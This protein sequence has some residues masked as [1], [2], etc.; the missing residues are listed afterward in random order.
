VAYI[1]FGCRSSS[2]SC[3]FLDSNCSKSHSGKNQP[4]VRLR[5]FWRQ[6]GPSP[7]RAKRGSCGPRAFITWAKVRHFG[8]NQTWRCCPGSDTCCRRGHVQCKSAVVPATSINSIGACCVCSATTQDSASEA[9]ERNSDV[10]M[11]KIS[12]AVGRLVPFANGLTR[13]DHRSSWHGGGAL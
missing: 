11:A 9:A 7:N 10:G 12:S 5:S 13:S 2:A 8:R 4:E 3:G 6:T 1:I